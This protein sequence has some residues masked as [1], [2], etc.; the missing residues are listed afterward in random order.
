MF[1]LLFVMTIFPAP[2]VISEIE[3]A[4]L[5]RMAKS[6]VQLTL[7]QVTGEEIDCHQTFRESVPPQRI[8]DW[9]NR[10]TMRETKAPPARRL[11]ITECSRTG[12]ILTD[13]WIRSKSQQ[14]AVLSY[15]VSRRWKVKRGV[16]AELRWNE[17]LTVTQSPLRCALS[18][19]SLEWCSCRTSSWVSSGRLANILLKTCQILFRCGAVARELSVLDWLHSSL[20][21]CNY[22]KCN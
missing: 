17:K 7:C 16:K 14:D 5:N 10:C 13:S 20:W 18:I 19:I 9:H 2:I 8:T 6:I 4:A 1:L 3:Q 11:E 12:N 21:S 22:P 15:L